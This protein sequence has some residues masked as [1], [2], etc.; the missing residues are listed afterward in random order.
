[1][2]VPA[3]AQRHDQIYQWR[4]NRTY[5]VPVLATW[6]ELRAQP[7]IELDRGVT[8]RLGIEA[9]R[10]PAG[11]GRIPPPGHGRGT[12]RLRRTGRVEFAVP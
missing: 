5:G 7:P 2:V 6:E 1:M 3:V 9:T 11:R 10:V 4:W 8:I 12:P